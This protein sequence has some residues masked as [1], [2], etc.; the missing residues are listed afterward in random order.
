ME[1][2]PAE[3]AAMVPTA[4]WTSVGSAPASPGI[5]PSRRST[6]ATLRHL[7]REVQPILAPRTLPQSGWQE[8]AK[9]M[10]DVFGSALGLIVLSPFF[11]VIAALIRIESPGSAFFQQTRVGRGGK[12]FKILKFRTMVNDAEKLRDKLLSRSLYSDPRLFKVRD[13]PRLTR[14]GRVLRRTSLDEL[15]QLVNVLRGEMSLVGPRPPL[16]SEVALYEQ[17]HYG[18]FDVMPGITGPW[19]VS[20]RNDITEFERVVALESEYIQDWSLWRDIGILFRTIPAVVTGRGA[21]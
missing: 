7:W 1:P 8:R 13:D 3:R 2:S 4:E 11:A 21:H 12:A 9:R 6:D 20:G 19:Q 17:R 10:L 14:M 16:P 5:S 15:P 18:R